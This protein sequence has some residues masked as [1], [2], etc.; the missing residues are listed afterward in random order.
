MQSTEREPAG[1]ASA[2]FGIVAAVLYVVGVMLMLGPTP[3]Y[4]HHK[5][6]TKYTAD[7]QKFFADGDK[8]RWSSWACT[9]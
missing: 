9:S 8:R 2:W 7:Y 1:R 4:K 3:S 5:S 6:P